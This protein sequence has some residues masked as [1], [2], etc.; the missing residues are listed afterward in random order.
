MLSGLNSGE[1]SQ[2]CGGAS[3]ERQNRA[4]QRLTIV[5]LL[6]VLLAIAVATVTSFGRLDEL[7]H[8]AHRVG[9]RHRLLEVLLRCNDGPAVRQSRNAPRAL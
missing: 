3:N 5:V 8:L 9:C 2:R 1:R 4:C 6:A 7:L